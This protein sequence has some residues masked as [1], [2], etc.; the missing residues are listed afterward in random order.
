MLE[1]GRSR[2][3]FLLALS[4][5][6]IWSVG[7]SSG[8][9]NG[10]QG[11]GSATGGGSGVGGGSGGGAAGGGSGGAAGGTFTFNTFA[12]NHP[13]RPRARTA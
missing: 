4:A 5:T 8:S 13:A 11:G 1:P 7:C 2:A 3:T 6:L 9:S 12:F 10:G